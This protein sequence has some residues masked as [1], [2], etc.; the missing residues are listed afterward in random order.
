ME[1]FHIINMEKLSTKGISLNFKM[2]KN[3]KG[4]EVFKN[5][6]L[7]EVENSCVVFE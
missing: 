5:G 3:K 7:R 2:T 6:A 4:K 1:Y